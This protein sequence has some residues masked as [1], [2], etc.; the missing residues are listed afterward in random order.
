MSI[1]SVMPSNHLTFCHPLLPCLQCFLASGSFLLSRIFTSG[2]QS[3]EALASASVHLMNIQDWCPLG[4]TDLIP[5]PSKELSRTFFNTSSKAS[6]LWLSAFFMVQL[7]HWY[8]STG[9]ATTLTIKNFIGKIVSLKNVPLKIKN[10][11][12]PSAW[13]TLWD[14]GPF[15]CSVTKSCPNLSDPLD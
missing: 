13:P 5:L 15:A 8:M 10:W 6:V 4:L 14:L 1:E 12:W 11:A 2:G 9:K 7:L 3:I